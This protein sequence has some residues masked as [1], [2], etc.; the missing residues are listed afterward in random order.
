M[1]IQILVNKVINKMAKTPIELILDTVEYIPTNTK[2]NKE[3]FPY[4]T[5][6]GILQLGEISIKVCVL[7]TGQKIIPEDELKRAFGG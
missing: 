2:P 7:N 4:I 1:M 6:E 3:G 5:H